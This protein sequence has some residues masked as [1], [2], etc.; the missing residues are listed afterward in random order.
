V[1]ANAHNDVWAVGQQVGLRGPD[2]ALVLHF[3]GTCWS[4]AA[5]PRD[6]HASALLLSVAVAGGAPLAVG[7]A[8]DNVV[9]PR[10]LAERGDGAQLVP[11]AAINVG[12]GENHLYGVA[13]LGDTAWTVG[14]FADPV[15][16]NFSTLIERVTDFQFA[17]SSSPNATTDGNNL[18][19]SVALTGNGEAWAVGSFDGAN[20]RQTLILHFTP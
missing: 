4:V 3:D 1:I 6:R 15:T 11:A 18:L 17:V 14:G 12:T 2:R 16:G 7:D 5:T 13:A 10:V 9:N 8:Q 19:S 20:A